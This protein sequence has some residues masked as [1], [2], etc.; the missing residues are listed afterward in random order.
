MKRKKRPTKKVVLLQ[1]KLYSW[2]YFYNTE[3]IRKMLNIRLEIIKL[4]E[5][6]INDHAG[7]NIWRFIIGALVRQQYNFFENCVTKVYICCVTA[8]TTLYIR[9]KV[10]DFSRFIETSFV[11]LHFCSLYRKNF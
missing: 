8:V 3:L 9:F 10:T 2:S 11:Y 4:H 5:C 6:D 7:N 1:V